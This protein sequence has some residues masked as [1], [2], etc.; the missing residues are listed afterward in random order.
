MNYEKEVTRDKT[1]PTRRERIERE[2]AQSTRDLVRAVL[3]AGSASKATKEADY[4]L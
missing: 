2:E 3:Q 1:I 4:G